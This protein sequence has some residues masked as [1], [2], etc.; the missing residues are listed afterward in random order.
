[1]PADPKLV[2]QPIR[3]WMRSI[4]AHTRGKGGDS[5]LVVRYE[6][7]NGGS[8]RRAGKLFVAIR[9]L[10]VN[11]TYQNLNITGGATSVRHIVQR[12]DGIGVDDRV[13]VRLVSPDGFGATTFDKGRDCGAFGDRCIAGPEG[14]RRSTVVG[15]GGDRVHL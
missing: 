4:K 2:M 15:I 14:N 6:L 10:Q 7:R 11:P 5:D 3:H 12:T 13:V 1:M 9:P 8:T